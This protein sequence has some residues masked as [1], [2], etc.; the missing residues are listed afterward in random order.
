M[1]S[2]MRRGVLLIT[3]LFLLLAGQ[4]CS[5]SPAPSSPSPIAATVTPSISGGP[6][7]TQIF[8]DVPADVSAWLRSHAVPFDTAEPRDDDSDLMPLKQMVGEARVVALGEATHG[9][10]EF[11]AMK[12]RVL[13]F[14]VKEMGFTVFGIEDGYAEVERINEYVHGRGEDAAESAISNLFQFPWETAE[15]LDMIKWVRAYNQGV[16][17]SAKISFQGFDMQGIAVPTGNVLAYVEKVDAPALAAIRADYSCLQDYER[18]PTDYTQLSDGAK[19]SCRANILKAYDSLAGKQTTYE[20]VS[21]PSEYASALHTARTLVQ[22]EECYS[23]LRCKNRERSMAENV[24][25]LVNQAGPSSKA[26]IWGHN[27]HVGT[28]TETNGSEVWKNMGQYLREKYAQQMVVFGFAFYE[29]SFNAFNLSGQPGPSRASLGSMA[30]QHV[31]PPPPDSYEH[32]L[33]SAGMP[34]L[35]LDLRH[36][37]PGSTSTSWLVGPKLLRSAG[38]AYD[39]SAPDKFFSQQSLPSLFDVVIYFQE[40]SPSHLLYK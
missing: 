21:T 34:R 20:A 5:D 39:S 31:T 30:V 10:H 2:W 32:Y 35:I 26:V 28:I 36:L 24:E 40:S 12:H 23:N 38:A 27:Q 15:M 19:E 8:A 22:A 16:S 14:L 17:A 37:E 9:T 25:W 4:G 3:C 13:E 11:F 6:T 1:A 33:A 29:G 18:Q 7:P